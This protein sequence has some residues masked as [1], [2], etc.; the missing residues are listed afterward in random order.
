MEEKRG[1]KREKEKGGRKREKEEKVGKWRKEGKGGEK[2]VK[3]GYDG[4][5][6]KNYFLERGGEMIENRNIYP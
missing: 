3:G 2:G 1:Q 5:G 4:L 6:K